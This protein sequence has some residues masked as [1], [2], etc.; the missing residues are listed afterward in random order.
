[1]Y[2]ASIVLMVVASIA[3]SFDASAQSPPA[4]DSCVNAIPLPCNTP[5]AFSTLGATDDGNF[6]CGGPGAAEVW[7]TVVGGGT[8]IGCST[9]F[10]AE[11]TG[12]PTDFDTVLNASTG[13][14]GGLDE[15]ICND[16]GP[17]DP[18]GGGPGSH[19]F[20]DAVPGKTYWVSVG[21]FLGATGTG[22]VACECRPYTPSCGN[23]IVDAGEDCDD[24]NNTSGDGCSA[25]CMAEVPTLGQWGAIVLALVLLA[26][27]ALLARAAR[28]RPSQSGRHAS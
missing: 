24:G 6:S 26:G 7:Y 16:N 3:T 27:G 11:Q 17:P 23:E 12:F 8:K 13:A 2:K 22:T 20:F 1:M 21:G 25:M 5:T 19:I 18:C 9:C 15:E 4:N 10:G 28:G 14:C